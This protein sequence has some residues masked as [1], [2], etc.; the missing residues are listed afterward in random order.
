[1]NYDLIASLELAYYYCAR[2]VERRRHQQSDES[3]D[4][5]WGEIRASFAGLLERLNADAPSAAD[6][7][8]GTLHRM[9]EDFLN[10]LELLAPDP[11]LVH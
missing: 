2:Q 1:M 9:V 8:E 10:Q 5:H 4:Q 7:R 6:D 11:G 3:Q